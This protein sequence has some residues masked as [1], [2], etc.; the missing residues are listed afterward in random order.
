MMFEYH[1]IRHVHL[2]ISSRCNAACPLCPR[3]LW[4]INGIIDDFHVCDLTLSQVKSIFEVDFLKQLETLLINGN[5]GDFVTCREALEIVEYFRNA[6]DKLQIEIQ[7]NGSGQPKIWSRLAELDVRVNFSIDGNRDTNHLYRQNTNFDLIIKNARTFI[8]AGGHAEWHCIKFDF[9]ETQ[10]DEIQQL[11]DSLKFKTFFL[12]DADRNNYH[13]FKK[14][15]TYDFSVG[16]PRMPKDFQQ[17]VSIYNWT[18]TSDKTEMYKKTESKKIDCL[19]KRGKSIYIAANGEVFPC[20]WTGFFPK[21]NNR[22]PGN[23]QLRHIL[24]DYDNNAI[25]VGLK[26]AMEW[27]NALE[28]TWHMSSVPEGKNY[29]CNETCGSKLE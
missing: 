9:N 8:E 25:E 18:K 17:L 7:T 15:G 19:A 20:C 27:F 2:E 12:R 24:K 13:V 26:K 28:S 23:D 4:G 22:M 11:S 6:N 5:Y 21:L 16:Q 3:N 1:E 10:L 29:I 14:D